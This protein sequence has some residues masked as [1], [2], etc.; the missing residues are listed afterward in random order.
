MSARDNFIQ[1]FSTLVR[2]IS[3]ASVLLPL[4]VFACTLALAEKARMFSFGVWLVIVLLGGI[5]YVFSRK[6]TA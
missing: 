2:W 5:L 4:V 3:I 1:P 6:P